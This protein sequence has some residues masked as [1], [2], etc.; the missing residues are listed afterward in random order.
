MS[1]TS[2][3]NSQQA[4]RPLFRE[5]AIS[6]QGHRM[7]GTVIL[8]Y[9]EIFKWLTA[10]IIVMMGLLIAFFFLFST[11]R[12]AQA[13][14]VLIPAAGLIKVIPVQAGIIMEKYIREG[15]AVKKGDVLFVLSG[16][17][18]GSDGQ[19][20]QKTISRLLESRRDSYSTEMHQV[21]EQST[22]RSQSLQQKIRDAEL[23]AVK[24]QDQI[25]LQ[26]QRVDMAE[27]NVKRFKEL[28]STNYISAA[29]LQERQADL[30]DQRQRLNEL[31]RA[32][33]NNQRD[34]SGLRA[35]LKDIQTQ[36][37]REKAAIERNIH[38]LSQDLTDNEA[39]RQ[40]IVR[41]T[42]D[43]TIAAV[44]AEKGQT[45]TPSMALATLLPTQTALEAELY[46]PSRSVGFVKPGMQVLV[47]YPAYPYQKFGQHQATVREIA[48][49][50]L[51]IDE[52]PP[53]GMQNT[54]E[55]LYRIRLVLNKQ[56]VTAYG[57]EY[58]L[59]PGMQIDA[60]IQLE[61]RRLY[62]WVLEPLYSISGRL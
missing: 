36:S 41:A 18:A 13:N 15:Q 51:R 38:A 54:N 7:Y 22:Q 10:A 52:L 3:E 45:V 55:P 31:Q 42:Q 34:L 62:E 50:P 53:S 8:Q 46:V 56:S 14:G 19:D 1:N 24:I 16:D 2:Q 60:S 43:G 39:R 49:S 28:Q 30:I 9:P 4:A 17:R 21:R 5:A 12:K 61:N 58:P 23:D 27:Q 32:I 29:Q 35:E 47:R 20:A 25:L 26:Q 48:Q 37:E 40:I 33:L 11:T 6:H 59:K 57:Q 44:N